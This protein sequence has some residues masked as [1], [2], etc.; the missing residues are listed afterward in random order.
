LKSPSTGGHQ[1]T[2]ALNR[3]TD[4]NVSRAVVWLDEMPAD[5][6]GSVSGTRTSDQFDNAWIQALTGNMTWRF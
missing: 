5:Q 6:T 1:A 4:V 2:Y 3:D